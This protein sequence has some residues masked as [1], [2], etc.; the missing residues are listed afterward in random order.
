M[1]DAHLAIDIN[2]FLMGGFRSGTTLAYNAIGVAGMED[3]MANARGCG[4]GRLGSVVH[5]RPED[6][7]TSIGRRVFKI[8]ILGSFRG[9]ISL[10]GAVLGDAT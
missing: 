9:P 6:R 2:S 8:F 4:G 3:W 1:F 10:F 7:G 5:A